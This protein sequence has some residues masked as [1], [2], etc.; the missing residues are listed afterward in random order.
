MFCSS[1][2]FH[3][4]FFLVLQYPENRA[5]ILSSEDVISEGMANQ[6]LPMKTSLTSRMKV[7][8]ISLCNSFDE[9]L[10]YL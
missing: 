2:V 3:S 4:Y 5:F 9:G 6:Y 7:D 10:V 8:L 1:S